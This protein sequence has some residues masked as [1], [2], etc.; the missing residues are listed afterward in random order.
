M[1]ATVEQLGRTNPKTTENPALVMVGV[2]GVVARIRRRIHIL[3]VTAAT[4]HPA[5]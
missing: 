5:W 1:A 2:V 3:S 4:A